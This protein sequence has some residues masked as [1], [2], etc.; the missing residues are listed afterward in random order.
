VNI[1]VKNI[2][3]PVYEAIKKE[4]KRKGRSLNAEIIKLLE[5]E[6]ADANRRIELRRLGAE[7]DRFAA[8]L[9]PMEDSTPLIRRG[10]DEH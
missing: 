8:S 6:A 9:P 2:P 4:A 5:A 3:D 10:R 1:T 7:L